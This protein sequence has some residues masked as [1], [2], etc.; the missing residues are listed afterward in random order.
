[1]SWAKGTTGTI[2]AGPG[3]VDTLMGD[4]SNDRY[5][6]RCYRVVETTSGPEASYWVKLDEA[7]F[8]GDGDG[9]YTSAEFLSRY[10]EAVNQA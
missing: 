10:L 8:D 5:S 9:P 1:M 6:A 2:A 3:I 7:Q 4:E